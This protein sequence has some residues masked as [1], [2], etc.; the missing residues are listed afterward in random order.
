MKLLKSDMTKEEYSKIVTLST[1]EHYE[2]NASILSSDDYIQ[3]PHDN[4]TFISGVQEDGSVI[5]I[6]PGGKVEKNK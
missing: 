6:I 2:I 5:C 3:C 1:P 4:D